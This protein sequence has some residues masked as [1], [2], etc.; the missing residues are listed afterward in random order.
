M[1]AIELVDDRYVDDT[2]MSAATLIADDFFGVQDAF[3]GAEISGVDPYELV[4]ATAT[5]SVNS[6]VIGF[7][8]GSDVLGNPLDVLVSAS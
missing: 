1:T 8:K 2:T 4:S 5:M 3:V 7:G 6:Q